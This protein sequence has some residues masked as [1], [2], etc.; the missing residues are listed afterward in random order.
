[1]QNANNEQYLQALN[2]LGMQLELEVHECKELY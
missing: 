2:I 1:M